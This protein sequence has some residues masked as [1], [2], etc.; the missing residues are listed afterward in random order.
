MVSIENAHKK[1]AVTIRK[2]EARV[3]GLKTDR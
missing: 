3:K 2:L 1:S